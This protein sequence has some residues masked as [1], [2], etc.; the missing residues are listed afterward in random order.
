MQNN[1]S[2]REEKIPNLQTCE[3]KSLKCEVKH[4]ALTP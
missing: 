3:E 1:T 2:N 4:P